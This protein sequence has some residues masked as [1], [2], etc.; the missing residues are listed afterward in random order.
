[1]ERAIE[2]AERQL[3]VAKAFEKTL[4]VYLAK[5]LTE[6]DQMAADADATLSDWI[7]EQGRSRTDAK[8][9]AL[10]NLIQDLD[11]VSSELHDAL[12]A[13]DT[14]SK[15]GKPMRGVNDL[16]VRD[17]RARLTAIFGVLKTGRLQLQR[18][19]TAV[20]KANAQ[21][22]DALA[23]IDN[24]EVEEEWA[25]VAEEVTDDLTE[26]GVTLTLVGEY[27]RAVK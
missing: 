18:M 2:L 19:V 26:I 11:S 23:L 10:D 20:D 5:M 25:D 4:S 3:K 16:I 24:T 9:T 22:D 14:P 13:C 21:V 8:S 12:Q 27:L 15:V 6:L 17:A 1:V 7:D